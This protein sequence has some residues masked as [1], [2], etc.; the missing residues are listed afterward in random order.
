[1]IAKLFVITASGVLAAAPALAGDAPRLSQADLSVA[2]Y[3]VKSG[4]PRYCRP[5]R[6]AG[7]NRVQMLCATHAEWRELGVRVAKR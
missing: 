5:V 6:A 7:E 4:E 1:M 2:R 3:P